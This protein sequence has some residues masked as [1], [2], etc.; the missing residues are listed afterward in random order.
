V[1]AAAARLLRDLALASTTNAPPAGPGGAGASVARRVATLVQ[2]RV[3]AL[4]NAQQGVLSAEALAL[5]AD[6][7]DVDVR[8]PA[9][10]A[11]GAGAG[12]GAGG[13]ALPPGFGECAER[14]LSSVGP[15]SSG[16]YLAGVLSLVGRLAGLDGAFRERLARG[17]L[18]RRLLEDFLI[19]V[20]D[21]I[22]PDSE[23]LCQ[24]SQSRDAAW[25]LLR[26]LLAEAPAV[27][28]DVVELVPPLARPASHFTG[29]SAMPATWQA[30]A[31]RR[32]ARPLATSSPAAT[33]RRPHRRQARAGD[34]AGA[35]RTRWPLSRARLAR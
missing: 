20:P 18:P 5:L 3:S 13:G 27:A 11:A 23:A 16:V 1:R 33:Q 22:T 32:P 6:L 28:A 34:A 25:S 14:L 35:S 17:G 8:C 10:P 2:R 30:R 12:A 29:K 15:R 24:D 26:V 4:Y 9:A 7:A 21:G 31:P 19:R